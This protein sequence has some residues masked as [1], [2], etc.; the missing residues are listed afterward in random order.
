VLCRL[1]PEFPSSGGFEHNWISELREDSMDGR[2]QLD[3]ALLN[4]LK[5]SDLAK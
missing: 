1:E 4:K 2:I 5:S 3:F